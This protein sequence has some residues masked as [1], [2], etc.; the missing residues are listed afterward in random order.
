MRTT[1]GALKTAKFGFLLLHPSVLSVSFSP[2]LSFT[3]VIVN[4][5]GCVCV[6]VCMCVCV[7]KWGVGRLSEQ[8]TRQDKWG[9]RRFEPWAAHKPDRWVKTDLKRLGYWWSPAGAKN[10]SQHWP[11]HTH[12][13]THIYNK[14]H[15]ENWAIELFSF[16]LTTWTF[17]CLEPADVIAFFV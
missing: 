7:L 12:T 17:R 6:C 9:D 10:T 2:N 14:K 3:L 8:E 13:H 11:E 4:H 16:F 1:K 15:T 5:W